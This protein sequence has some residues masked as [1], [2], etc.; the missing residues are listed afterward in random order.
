MNKNVVGWFEIPVTDMDRAVKFYETVFDIKLSRHNLGPLDMAW[1][2][3]VEDGI[4]TPGSLVFNRQAYKP[5][6]D[7]VLI[8]FTAFSGD[9]SIELSRVENAGGKVLRPK[10]LISEDVGY[11]ALCSDSEGNRFALHCRK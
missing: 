10:T 5:S 4:G 3:S 6:L 7:G 9:V 1:F 8:Y 11:M 2:P